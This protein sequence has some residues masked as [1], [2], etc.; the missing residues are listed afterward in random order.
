MRLDCCDNIGRS[1][2]AGIVY[3]QPGIESPSTHLLKLMRKGVSYLQNV[4]FI[5]CCRE[6]GVYASWNNLIRIPGEAPEDYVDMERLI[7]KI[8]HLNPPQGGARKIECHRFSPYFSGEAKGAENI[9]PLSWYN[10]IFPSDDFNLSRVAYFFLA[11]WEDTLDDSIYVP[12]ITKT[13]DWLKIWI[14]QQELPQLI[15]HYR[16]DGTLL[17]SDTRYGPLKEWE[18]GAEEAMVY[19]SISDP[20][21]RSRVKSF[22]TEEKCPASC[23]VS[24]EE[25]ILDC[26]QSFVDDGLA[27]EENN[28]YLGLALPEGTID[29]PY[30]IRCLI[31][32]PN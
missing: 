27:I 8:V 20:A 12:V 28:T 19:R 7:P 30:S 16:D 2:H 31:P 11:D 32:M 18:Y 9:K 21:S 15:S 24:S 29:P 10:A 13:L 26:L 4:F 17:I 22:I 5:K 1:D 25:D 14:N 23:S 6:H 3:L